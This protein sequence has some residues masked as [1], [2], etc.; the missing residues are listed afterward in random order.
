MKKFRE[1]L[2]KFG[3]AMGEAF[4]ELL[5][6]LIF[7]GLGCGVFALFGKT[8]AFTTIDADALMLVGLAVLIILL[9]GICKIIEHLRK[10]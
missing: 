4:A 5:L 2:R 10:K 6:G 7:I 9:L 8:D 3:E 1:Y